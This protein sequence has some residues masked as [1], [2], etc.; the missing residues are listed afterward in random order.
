MAA[1][2]TPR[3]WSLRR[4]FLQALVLGLIPLGTA[5]A[6]TFAQSHGYVQVTRD[7]T[8]ID[9]FGPTADVCMTAPKGTILE[10]LYI[11]GD[12]FDHRRS[13]WYWV[14]LPPDQYGNRLSGWVRGNEVEHIQPPQNAAASKTSPGEVAPVVDARNAP[15]DEAM[16]AP[17]ETA[18]AAPRPVIAEVILNFEFGKSALTEDARQKLEGAI[19]KPTLNANLIAVALEGH[20]DWIGG[21]SYNDQLGMARAES[22]KR[23]MTEHLGIPA[24]RISVVS[25]GENNPVASNSTREG[26]AQNRRVVIR[27]GGS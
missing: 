7:G 27:N 26:R 14:L 11:D 2:V 18:P 24:E 10:V 9:C 22:V 4:A 5:S 25:Y 8:D 12:R 20:A 17:V 13:N 23:Y 19:V 15:R 21:E 1:H 16:P 6:Q 3:P